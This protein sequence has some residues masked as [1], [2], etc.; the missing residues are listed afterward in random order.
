MQMLSVHWFCPVLI[1]C[2]L[3]VNRTDSGPED[4]DSEEGGTTVLHEDV[5]GLPPLLHLPHEVCVC[6]YFCPLTCWK[7]F[8]MLLEFRICLLKLV[9]V[10]DQW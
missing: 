4:R 9:E 10:N 2:L 3:C 8:S 7:V 1:C 5:H 6:V